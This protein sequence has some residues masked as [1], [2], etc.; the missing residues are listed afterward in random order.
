MLPFLLVASV[1]ALV[2]AAV[3]PLVARLARRAGAVD[4]P[5]ER[6]VHARPVP[7]MGGLAMLAGF[8]AAFA[9][10]AFHPAFDELFTSS[11]EPVGVLAGVVVIA[12]DRR[13][14]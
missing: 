6:K 12:W 7:T 9:V 5:D 13:R 11:S 14:S 4:R 10:A 8:V 2:T 3:T 1:A